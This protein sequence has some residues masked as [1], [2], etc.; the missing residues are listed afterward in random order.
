MA[1]GLFASALVATA[2][3]LCAAGGASAATLKADYRFHG[4]LA[5]SVAGSPPAINLG[6]QNAFATEN[7]GGAPRTVLTFPK[8]AGLAF[9]PSGVPADTYTIAVLFRLADLTTSGGTS[10]RRILDFTAGDLELGVYYYTGLLNYYGPCCEVMGSDSASPNRYE[11][12]VFTRTAGNQFA[13][14]LN[15]VFQWNVGGAEVDEETL[16]PNGFRLFKDDGGEEAAGAVARV[17]IWD[18]ALSASEVAGLDLYPPD[19]DGDG[20][21]DDFDNCPGV[22]NADQAD[23]DQDG[24]GDPCDADDDNDG[25]ADA[26]D[27]YPLDPTRRWSPPTASDDLI[28]ASPGPDL[29]C[30]LGGN[31][32]INGLG[33]DDT[34]FGDA[35]NDV[36]RARTAQAARDGNDTL[37]GDSGNDRLYGA[38]GND[39]LRGGPGNDRLYGGGGNDTLNGGRGRNSYSGGPGNDTIRARNAKKETVNCGRGRRDRASVDRK[40]RVRG[41]ERVKRVPR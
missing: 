18:G 14:F 9:A 4:N 6:D 41:C 10:Y 15:G 24:P 36:A 11:Q 34:I 33:G 37:I 31:D 5:S 28:T 16:M 20:R 30:G 32:T 38:G 22:A 29:I 2:V 13:G 12:V 8:D 25:V 3:C 1:R 17:R 19:S 39:S 27:A 7:A 35:C 26:L 40:D 23:V 21:D